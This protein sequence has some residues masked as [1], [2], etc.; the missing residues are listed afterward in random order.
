M[1][2]HSRHQLTPVSYDHPKYT[3]CIKVLI[4]SS[5]FGG[6]QAKTGPASRLKVGSGSRNGNHQGPIHVQ[7]PEWVLVAPPS[8]LRDAPSKGLLHS[9]QSCPPEYRQSAA[10]S[11]RRICGNEVNVRGLEWAP[12]QSSWDNVALSF[13]YDSL[14]GRKG[15]E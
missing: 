14:E 3:A 11:G 10:T 2:S 13:L 5:A 1:L 6:T 15:F 8:G 12:S 4:T 9:P 7:H